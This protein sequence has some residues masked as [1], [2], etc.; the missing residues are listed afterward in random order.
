MNNLDLKYSEYAESDP[1]DPDY[2]CTTFL[3]RDSQLAC[4]R[5][6]VALGT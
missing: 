3:S 4:E 1:S 2:G 6:G 5:Q